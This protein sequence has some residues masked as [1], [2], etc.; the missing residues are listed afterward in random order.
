MATAS[1]NAKSQFLLNKGT[2]MYS[3]EQEAVANAVS[4]YISSDKITVD[5]MA[6]FLDFQNKES[7]QQAIDCVNFIKEHKDVLRQIVTKDLK[8]EDVVYDNVTVR[9]I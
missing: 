8:P 1:N 7:V 4:K 2:S 9:D 6:T 3:A 5:K